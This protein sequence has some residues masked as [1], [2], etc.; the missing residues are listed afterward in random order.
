M[1][2]LKTEKKC[3]KIY[4]SINKKITPDLNKQQAAKEAY[5]W[6]LTSVSWNEAALTEFVKSRA[7][8]YSKFT[9]GHRVKAK[10]EEVYSVVLDFDNGKPTIQEF[11]DIAV[12][13]E[14]PWFLH[15]TTSHGK[16]DQFGNPIDKFRVIIPLSRSVSPDEFE[17]IKAYFLFTKD[18]HK[19]T[20]DESC[21]DTNRYFYHSINAETYLHNYNN[22]VAFLNPTELI[23]QKSFYVDNTKAKSSKKPVDKSFTRDDEVMLKDKTQIKLKDITS[24]TEIFCPFCIHDSAHRGNPDSANAF[25]DFNEKVQ[26]FIYCS[27]ENKT[28]WEDENKWI[29]KIT[30]SY[31]SLDTSIYQAGLSGDV[32]SFAKIGEKK[33]FS[34]LGIKDK[35]EREKIYDYV[36]NNKHFHSLQRVDTVSNVELYKSRYNID[37]KNGLVTVDIA[38]LQ[39]KVRD[40]NFIDDYFELVFGQYKDFIKEWLAV[41]FYTNYKKLPHLILLGERGSGKNTFA[42][43]IGKVFPTLSILVKNL[44]GNFNPYAEK[45]LMIIDESDSNGKVQYQELKKLSGQ[46][47]IEVN[48]KYLPQ[49]M[50]K[51]NVNV[52]FLSNENNPIFV[53]REE[54]PIDPRNNQFFVYR[55]T[56]NYKTIDPDLNQKLVDRLTHYVRTELKDVYDKLSFEGYRYSIEVPITEEEKRLF[57]TSYTDIEMDTDN[58]VQKLIELMEGTDFEWKPFIDKGYLPSKFFESYSL[59]GVRTSKSKII[60]NLQDRGFLLGSDADKAQVGGDR[61]YCYKLGK[62]W[63]DKINN[64]ATQYTTTKPEENKEQ[65][66][67]FPD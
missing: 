17:S 65:K 41:Y 58:Y 12:R 38:P 2:Q 20:I 61:K 40:N 29:E 45:K 34:Q 39:E 62:L 52:M 5:D 3:D 11:K 10:V 36:I 27:S 15:T 37:S 54:L 49:Y 14:F 6:E 30:E 23:K 59:F 21:F 19:W 4:F 48:K 9:D 32:F 67:L 28:Y 64:N 26:M 46:S 57:R 35:K 8:C 63:I 56:R 22:E 42:E 44:H 51:N 66:E 33:M 1:K 7:Y 25:V 16:Q 31:W 47:E 24:H 53:E 55:F 13:W 18:R 60:R 43:S 50:T